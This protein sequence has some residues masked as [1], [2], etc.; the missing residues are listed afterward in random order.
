MWESVI[1]LWSKSVESVADDGLKRII[2]IPSVAV[3]HNCIVYPFFLLSSSKGGRK[4]Y[5]TY[6]RSILQT[7]PSGELQSFDQ[8]WIVRGGGGL[9]LPRAVDMDVYMAFMWLVDEL[10][11][12]PENGVVPFSFY[13]LVE[14]LRW[15]GGGKNFLNLRASIERTAAA[16]ITSRKAFWS[17]RAQTYIDDTIHL[18]S[19]SL[20]R[21]QD[22]TGRHRERH[23]IKFADLVV[24]SYLNGYR[25]SL[26][27]EFYQSLKSSIAKR[28]YML[29]EHFADSPSNGVPRSWEITPEDLRDLMP[30]GDYESPAKIEQALAHGT[31]ELSAAGYFSGIEVERGKR[32]RPIKFRFVVSNGFQRKRLATAVRSSPEGAI[33]LHKLRA[34]GVWWNSAVDLVSVFGPEYC[35]KYADLLP[36]RKG[37]DEKKKGG[38]LVEAIKEGAP[39]EEQMRGRNSIVL[40]GRTE[41]DSPLSG[42]PESEETDEEDGNERSVEPEPDPVASRV[43]ADV[44]EIASSGIDTPAFMMW[45]ENTVPTAWDGSRMEI[46]VPNSFAKEYI[47]SRFEKQIL[48]GLRQRG[49]QDPHLV[50]KARDGNGGR[51]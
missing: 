28:L 46:S 11:G 49:V 4:D 14:I 5:F 19:S 39:W 35:S 16:S 13:E 51:G 27:P 21:H 9:G 50:V 38:L 42:G 23:H 12:M 10:G 29:N 25:V 43:W 45:F 30:L 8:E 2:D 44:L 32:N 26:E 24:E 1:A 41:E 22:Y 34:Q 6:R 31:E 18:F 15:T 20:K 7:N 17:P 40:E 37:L 48:G 33:A 47:E 3:E 36:F